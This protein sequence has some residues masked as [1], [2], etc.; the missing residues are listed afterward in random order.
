MYNVLHDQYCDIIGPE[1]A[2]DIGSFF[3]DITI[4]L[5]W[6]KYEFIIWLYQLNQSYIDAVIFIYSRRHLPLAPGLR[7]NHDVKHSITYITFM[8]CVR[9][10]CSEHGYKEISRPNQR[11]S[12]VTS[13]RSYDEM[14][15]ITDSIQK[16]EL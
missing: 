10:F 4:V 6:N 12:K 13:K 15:S 8:K 5:R 16:L 2:E 9:E 3:D 14:D 7:L 1:I 11:T